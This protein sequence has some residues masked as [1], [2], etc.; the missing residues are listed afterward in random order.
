ME[1]IARREA[2]Q[3]AAEAARPK[4]SDAQKGNEPNK[5]IWQE[6]DNQQYR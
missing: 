3:R 1:R 5:I 2:A 4:K 6:A